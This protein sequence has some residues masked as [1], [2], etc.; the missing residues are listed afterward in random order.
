MRK[1]NK[2]VLIIILTLLLI[3]FSNAQ[4]SAI[5]DWFI[6]FGNQKISNRWNFWNEVQYRNYNFAGDLQ[7][8]LL[9]TNIGW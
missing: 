4:K 8:L 1:K 7:Q 2:H 9:R 6:Y 5:G 3:K